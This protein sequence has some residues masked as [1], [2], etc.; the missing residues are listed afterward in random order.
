MAFNIDQTT[1]H[2]PVLALRGLVLFPGTALSFD[3]VRKR[4]IAAL[5]VAM[6][7]DRMIYAVTQRDIFSEE[8]QTDD[9]YE[10]GCVAKVRQV[11]KVTDEITKVV[12]EGVRRATATGYTERFGCPFAE[13]S[14]YPDKPVRNRPVPAFHRMEL[15]LNR[16]YI[17]LLHRSMA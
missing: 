17:P 5:K 10:I 14:D 6:E 8:P 13:V 4:S 15:R 2:L 12:L 3:V 7:H 11:L 9:L 1:N 16:S